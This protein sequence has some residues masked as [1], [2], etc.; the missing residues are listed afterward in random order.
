[1]EKE[2]EKKKPTTEERVRKTK[3]EKTQE[4]TP[5]ERGFPNA[6]KRGGPVAQSSTEYGHN[7]TGEYSKK[8]AYN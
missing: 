3:R 4:G 7:R 6:F 5:D 8:K 1:V 2:R